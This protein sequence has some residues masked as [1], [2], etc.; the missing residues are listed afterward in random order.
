MSGSI[1]FADPKGTGR[2]THSFNKKL[3]EFAGVIGSAEL[4][5]SNPIRYLA[6]LKGETERCVV[7]GRKSETTRG[8]SINMPHNFIGIILM[9]YQNMSIT[10]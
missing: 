6:L 4:H 10:K 2:Q 5:T 9:K 3:S 1:Y 7:R 8:K